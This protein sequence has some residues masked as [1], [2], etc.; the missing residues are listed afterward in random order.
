[1]DT[2][3]PF[4]EPISVTRPLL[5]PLEDVSRRLEEVW[6]AKWLTNN[7]AQLQRL[8]RALAT[9]LKAPE[10]MAFN[11]G[12]IA[13]MIGLRALDLS[14]EVITTPFTF[15]A[16]THSL[17]WNALRPVFC[18]I[19][20]TTMCIDPDRIEALITPRTTAILG[21]HVYGNLCDAARIEA[22]AE[23][24]GLKVIYD[25]AHA[26][27]VEK[28]GRS[29]AEL[30]DLT[31]YSFHAT[32]LFHTAEGGAL[33]FRAPELRPVIER[34]RNFGIENEESI[35]LPGINGKVNELQAALG[36]AVL[37]CVEA[38]R[39]RRVDVFAT[40]ER[41]LRGIDGLTTPGPPPTR[42]RP[43]LQYYVIRIDPWRFG[44]SRDDLHARLKEFNVHT[45]KYFH[46][47]VSEFPCYADVA[48]DA[49]PVARRVA[50]EVISLP[51]YGMLG[52]EGASRIVQMIRFVRDTHTKAR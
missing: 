8:E 11:N 49:L 22:I 13:L 7:G 52:V 28:D 5:P 29:V 32:K 50:Q 6:A 38:E 9:H 27:G 18:D 46:P 41:E 4:D 39:A 3:C 35:T 25:A 15:A 19:D 36:L 10:L 47:L 40:Y 23:R 17:V 43:S 16:T 21:V 34:L 12:T 42:Q 51:C 37:D 44:L 33:A 20:P 24:R 1:M 2:P 31:M 14:G 45:R 48:S 26:F 30:G